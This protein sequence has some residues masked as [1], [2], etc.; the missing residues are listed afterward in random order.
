MSRN[1]I[2]SILSYKECRSKIWSGEKSVGKRMNE[3]LNKNSSH[4][5]GYHWADRIFLLLC[6]S[7]GL[8]S[9]FFLFGPFNIY[10]GNLDE[11]A[12]TLPSMFTFF[13]LPASILIFILFSIGLAL[14]KELYTRY[15]SIIFA[16]NVLS[17]L[18]GNIIVWEYGVLDGTAVD[19]GTA[20]WRG[21]VDALGPR[22]D[23]CLCVF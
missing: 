7:I 5:F 14:P 12:L 6:I 13:L 21:W 17:W 4:R 20:V 16:V 3:P 11:F 19:W 9:N 15:V 10:Q 8:T 23:Y 2:F 22:L 1:V 18:Q